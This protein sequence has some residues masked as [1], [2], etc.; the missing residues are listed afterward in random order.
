M[1]IIF[2][3][4]PE[5]LYFQIK[6]DIWENIQ[7]SFFYLADPEEDFFP[8]AVSVSYVCCIYNIKFF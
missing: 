6:K 1:E 4:Q 8:T 2:H 7:C 5:R 3:Y